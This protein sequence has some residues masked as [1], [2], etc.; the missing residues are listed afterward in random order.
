VET[1]RSSSRAAEVESILRSQGFN[2]ASCVPHLVAERGD[3][4]QVLM[5]ANRV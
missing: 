5:I 3:T 2:I 1:D 4:A